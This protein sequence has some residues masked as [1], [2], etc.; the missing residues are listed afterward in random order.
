MSNDV[1]F[2]FPRNLFLK[3][4]VSLSTC[5]YCVDICKGGMLSDRV[6]TGVTGG[7]AR[8]VK[9]APLVRLTRCDHGCK[10]GEGV[11]TGLRSFGP[12]KD[13]GSHITF[14]VVR[15]TRTHKTLGPKT[16]VVRPADNG[17]NIKLTV[18]TAVGKCRLVLAVPRAVDIR[19][20]GLL[21]TLNTRVMLASKLTNVTNSVTGTGRLQSTVPNTIV[22]R[23]FRGPSGT[24]TRRRAAKRR[25]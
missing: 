23:R 6:V 4:S 16:A 21:G 17:A 22:L 10:L 9:R 1:V 2:P 24:G 7:L 5:P 15:S 20:H 11:I 8:L 18:M 14:T 25:V 13:I 12:T 3:V 19:H